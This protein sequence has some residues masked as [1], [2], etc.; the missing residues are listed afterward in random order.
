MDFGSIYF[1]LIV[2]S[3]IVSCAI[4]IVCWKDLWD[5]ATSPVWIAVQCALFLWFCVFTARL[6]A[7]GGPIRG[8]AGALVTV[9]TLVLIAALHA[10]LLVSLLT[11]LA[12]DAFDGMIDPK[13]SV[14]VR[15]SYDEAEKAEARHEYDRALELLE[16][17][18]SRDPK[19]SEVRTKIGNLL[20]RL[21]R[22]EEAVAEFSSILEMEDPDEK[23]IVYSALRAADILDSNLGRKVDAR[24]VLD[25]ALGRDLSAEAG[26]AIGTRRKSCG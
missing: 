8:L 18:R 9:L 21:N 14:V 2:A 15:K 22:F 13:S 24:T 20:A 26:K 10:P 3:G 6:L 23:D 17:E 19:D 4:G 5:R 11:K 16:A 12:Q 7:T 25:T 1:K